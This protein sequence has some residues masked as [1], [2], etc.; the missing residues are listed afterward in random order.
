MGFLL[1]QH[2]GRG[3][4]RPGLFQ[5]A[6]IFRCTLNTTHRPAKP[7][8]QY[9]SSAGAVESVTQH[10]HHSWLGAGGC[11]GWT[12]GRSD[13]RRGAHALWLYGFSIKTQQG[14]RSAHYLRASNTAM[15]PSRQSSLHLHPFFSIVT[16]S[17]RCVVRRNDSETFLRQRRRQDGHLY[18][19]SLTS[20]CPF[21]QKITSCSRVS[22][23]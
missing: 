22:G 19:L 10:S 13:D 16:L 6:L 3:R 11:G 7:S 5:P 8:R 23:H 9:H 18:V 14:R 12:R 17:R 21:I 20:L 1:H 15:Y 4:R 2:R